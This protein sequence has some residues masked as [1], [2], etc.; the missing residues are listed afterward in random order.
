MTLY[1]AVSNLKELGFYPYLMV[2]LLFV[3]GALLIVPSRFRRRSWIILVAIWGIFSGLITLIVHATFDP[4]GD[5]WSYYNAGARLNAHLPLYL[6]IEQ[7]PAAAFYH[8]PPLLAIL[9]RPLSLLP[10]P[11]AASLWEFVL[12][13]AMLGTLWLLGLRRPRVWVA[14]AILAAPLSWALSIGQSQV[15][16]TAALALASPFGIALAANLKLFPLLAAVFF[17]GRRDW[18]SLRHLFFWIIGLVLLQL[19]LEPTG[20]LTYLPTL[21]ENNNL[22]S[23]FLPWSPYL[24]SPLLWASL[25]LIGI[26][27]A[28]RLARGSHG[29]TAA[30]FLAVL[31]NPWLLLYSL[32]SLLAVMVEN[33]PRL[34]RLGR[35]EVATGGQDD[36]GSS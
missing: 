14:I 28:L 26:L 18:R 1:Q 33:R 7:G 29:W 34:A 27:L 35:V 13:A 36:P 16:V 9:W 2:T 23:V 6:P 20:T 30:V 3:M 5:I 32:S 12:V 15:L 4:G 22:G 31:A 11:V 21:L 10:F 17:V 19:A 25:V 24:F 8:Q